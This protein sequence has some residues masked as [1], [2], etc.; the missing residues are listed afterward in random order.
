MEYKIDTPSL[1][2]E[3]LIVDTFDDK[4]KWHQEDLE[5]IGEKYTAL[6][7]ITYKKYLK[8]QIFDLGKSSYVKIRYHRGKD[9]QDIVDFE[10]IDYSAQTERI[11]RLSQAIKRQCTGDK[12]FKAEYLKTRS[13]INDVKTALLKD[14]IIIKYNHDFAYF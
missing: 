14:I 13:N 10:S 9:W 11:M 8:I 3:S 4:I 6:I 1:F 5:F 2:L 12:N 7:N